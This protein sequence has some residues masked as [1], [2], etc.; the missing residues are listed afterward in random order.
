MQS[1]YTA[2]NSMVKWV[3]VFN[4]YINGVQKNGKDNPDM[5]KV[6]YITDLKTNDKMIRDSPPT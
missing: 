2:Y 6:S 1:S 4:L 3:F 5:L